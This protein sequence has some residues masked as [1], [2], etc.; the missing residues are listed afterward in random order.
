MVRRWWKIA[1]AVAAVL[2]LMAL[3]RYYEPAQRKPKPHYASYWDK[4]HRYHVLDA[5]IVSAPFNALVA[6]LFA[7]DPVWWNRPPDWRDPELVPSVVRARIRRTSR[8]VT[9][10]CSLSLLGIVVYLAHIMDLIP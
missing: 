9:A 10:L 5:L 6:L 7:L 1:L 8:I 3:A 4:P 2:A